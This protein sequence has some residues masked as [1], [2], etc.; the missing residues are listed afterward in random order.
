MERDEQERLRE[1][2]KELKRQKVLPDIL[3]RVIA[4]APLPE[5]REEAWEMFRDPSY[6]P[7]TKGRDLVYLVLHCPRVREKAA[8]MLLARPGRG[9]ANHYQ[10]R[11]VI[12][13]VPSLR[14]RAAR[15]LL[16]KPELD[17]KDIMCIAKNVPELQE[18]ALARRKRPQEV[19]L[20]DLTGITLERGF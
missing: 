13:N 5:I 12:E 10:L 14:E 6:Y 17:D 7:R 19:I 2:W 1:L 11:V 18:E 3:V 4:Y 15:R 20:E 9:A 16:K 8:E